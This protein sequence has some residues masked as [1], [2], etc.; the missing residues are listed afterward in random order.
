[1]DIDQALADMD[2]LTRQLVR[3]ADDERAELAL[4]LAAQWA[5]VND[6]L[7]H[8]GHL[9]ARWQPRPAVV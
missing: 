7:S 8:G 5:A 9:P 4:E 2:S 6:W 3:A 1:M